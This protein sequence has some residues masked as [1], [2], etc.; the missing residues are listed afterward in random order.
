MAY[1]A[2]HG[3]AQIGIHLRVRLLGTNDYLREFGDPRA[4]IAV[5]I[6]GN[7]A[8]GYPDASEFFTTSFDRVDHYPPSANPSPVGIAAS[9]LHD[10]YPITTVPNIHREISIGATIVPGLG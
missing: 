10:G 1:E 7:Y 9:V 4:K 5:A 3:L 8:K 6:V 2:K